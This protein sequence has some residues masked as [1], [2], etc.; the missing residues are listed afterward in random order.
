MKT[1]ASFF[2]FTCLMLN[3]NAQKNISGEYY[4]QGVMETASGFKL[5]AD[6]SFEFFFSYGALDRYGS[7]KWSINKDSIILNSKS[8]P[9]KDFKLA[10]SVVSNNKFSTIKIEEKNTDLYQMIYCLVKSPDQDSI[11]RFDGTGTIVLPFAADSI[12]FLSEL[13]SERFSAFTLGKSPMIYTFNI[14][15]WILEVFFNQTTFYFTD[16]YLE[17]K[18]PLLDDKIYR[19]EKEK[20]SDH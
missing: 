2:V 4:L 18:H 12:I 10:G 7:G 9:G 8:S 6:S 16:D 20:A 1:A 3:L 5:N 14:Q 11:I 17:G 19:F 13:C 15:P